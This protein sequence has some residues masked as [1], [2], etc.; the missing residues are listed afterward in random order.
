MTAAGR[1]ARTTKTDPGSLMTGLAL[2]LSELEQAVGRQAE[3]FGAVIDIGAQITG[4]RDVDALL[5]TVIHRLS[6]LLGA[7]A[8]TLF[9]FD[10]EAGELWSRVLKGSALKEIRIPATAG[11]AGQ[12]FSTGRT[13]LLGDAYSDVRFNPEID[14]QSGFRTRSVIAA[15]LRHVSG[16]VLGVIEVLSKHVDAFTGDDRMLVEGVASQVAAVLDNVR[17]LEQLKARVHDLDVLYEL[18]QEI[19]ST[20]EQADLLERGLARACEVLQARAGS[21]L[22]VD[23][24]RGT[25]YFK[26]ARGEKSEALVAMKM[27]A[28]KG[29][30]GWVA[31]TG[32]TVRTAEA[33]AHER[34]DK[35]VARKLGLTV[36]ALLCVP[37]HA[38]G[39]LLGALELL[40]K[41]GG[42]TQADERLAVLLAAQLGRAM[43]VSQ[44]RGEHQRRTR[45][46]TIGQMLAGVMHDLRTPLS[47]ISGYAEMMAEEGDAASR[48]EMSK[49]ILRVLGHLEAMQAETLAFARGERTVLARKVYLQVFLKDVAEQ[50]ARDFERSKVELKVV[51]AYTGPAKFDENKL[52]RAIF[53]LARNARDAMPQGGRFTL[54]VDR[55]GEDLVFTAQDNGP[56]IPGEIA[57]RL[58]E[59]FVTAGKKHGTGL[60][61]AIVKQIAKEHGGSVRCKSRP[62]KGATFEIRVPAGLPA[63]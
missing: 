8:A 53:N 27:P 21:V 48:R 10:E 35:T 63:D 20:D 5:V 44:S 40:N 12:C 22:L 62:G 56:G 42:F 2:K 52:K 37:I 15:P 31:T 7:D 32:S 49:E 60:G 28:D 30:A 58:F 17:L 1:G 3:R 45:L 54:T 38:E 16:R 55:A 43:L 47:V 50:L 39:R 36:A 33:E 61:L 51:P 14:R 23:E 29:I 59:S 26:S 34:Y 57:D 41:K 11:I 24:E 25:L 13:L 6:A 46:E 19:S 4:A 9:M 18:E